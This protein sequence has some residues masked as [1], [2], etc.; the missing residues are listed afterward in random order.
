MKSHFRQV[1]LIGKHPSAV[2]G[3][4]AGAARAALEDIGHFLA[5]SGCDVV[6]EQGAAGKA[7]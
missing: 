3:S 7:T 5:S 6:L 2:T 1:A 4:R